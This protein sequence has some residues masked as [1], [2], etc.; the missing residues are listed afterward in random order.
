M[1]SVFLAG[2]RTDV[3]NADV[4]GVVPEET[5]EEIRQA[6]EISMGTE[7]GGVF[8][9]IIIIIKYDSFFFTTKFRCRFPRKIKRTFFTFVSRLAC[10][11]S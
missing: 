7:V 5:E 4:S 10:R 9:N 6:A 3:E 8:N 11:E 1:L 2:H